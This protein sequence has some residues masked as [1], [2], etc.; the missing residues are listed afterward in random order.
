[1]SPEQARGKPVDARADIWAFGVVLYEM[2][3]GRRLFDGETISE[4][5]ASVI[6][7]EPALDRIPA[8]VRRLLRRCRGADRSAGPES[9]RRHDPQ[10]RRAEKIGAF[11]KTP[12][13]KPSTA[14]VTE[15]QSREFRLVRPLCLQRPPR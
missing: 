8:N 6:K 4:T 13:K 12:L 7:E 15:E 2:I 5:L 14:E 11:H 3:E 9:K 10:R 1:M